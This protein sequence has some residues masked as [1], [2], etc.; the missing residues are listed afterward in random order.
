MTELGLINR[1]FHGKTSKKPTRDKL[2]EQSKPLV[3]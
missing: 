1:V 3:E 2:F